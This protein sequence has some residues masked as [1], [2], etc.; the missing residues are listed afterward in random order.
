MKRSIEILNEL[1]QI[2]PIVAASGNENIFTVPEKYFDTVAGTVLASINNN[3]APAGEVPGGYFDALSNTILSKIE[4]TAANELV[5]LSPLLASI[6]KMNPF[7]VPENY[8]E[9]TEIEIYSQLEGE[10]SSGILEKAVKQTPFTVPAGYFDQLPVAILNKAKEQNR[11]K[12][13]TLTTRRNT[14]WKYAAAA[15]FTGLMTFGV[16]KYSSNTTGI[17]NTV[18]TAMTEDAFNQN[19]GNLGE[20][21]IIKYLEKN[22]TEED[23]A[24]LT[25]EIYEAD[26]PSQE[27]Y[28][29]DD[30]TLD[31]FL[32]EIEL[33][34]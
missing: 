24:I 7:E 22:S 23:L 30:A 29:T 8:F 13:V 18:A 31:K 3:V 2:S 11:A 17:E 1:Q 26:L 14:M 20:E 5:Q 33:K 4:G 15:I 16:Y 21:D 27:D 25:S 32:D 10:K 28:F 34:N 9:Q 19:L 12:V 6:N